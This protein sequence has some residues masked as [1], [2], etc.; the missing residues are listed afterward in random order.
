MPYEAPTLLFPLLP[1]AALCH[2]GPCTLPA[3]TGFQQPEAFDLNFKI[4]L[5]SW[6]AFVTMCPQNAGFD[7]YFLSKF[8]LMQAYEV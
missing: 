1:N 4:T 2:I 7:R 5:G 6:R 3:I 8:Y